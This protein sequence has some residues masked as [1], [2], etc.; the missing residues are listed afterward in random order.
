[1][2]TNTATL[3]GWQ[4]PKDITALL[5]AGALTITKA[6]AYKFG[7][8]TTIQITYSDASVAYIKFCANGHLIV[9]GVDNTMATGTEITWQS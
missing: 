5:A 8:Q 9:G 1:M 7:T 2:S 3:P 6:V 4:T